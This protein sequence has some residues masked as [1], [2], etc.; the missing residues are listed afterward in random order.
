MKKVKTTKLKNQNALEQSR[1][2]Q[3]GPMELFS[4]CS[5]DCGFIR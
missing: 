1:K 5:A 3:T 4:Q 2:T